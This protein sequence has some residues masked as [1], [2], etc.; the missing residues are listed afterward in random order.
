MLNKHLFGREKKC[1]LLLT[2]TKK[3]FLKINKIKDYNANLNINIIVKNKIYKSQ[4]M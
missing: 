1:S 3:Y 4:K 2:F